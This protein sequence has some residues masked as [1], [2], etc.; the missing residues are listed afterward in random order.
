MRAVI[1]EAFGPIENAAIGEAPDPTPGPGEVLVDV[2]ATAA[3]Y[4]D[5]LLIAGKHQSRPPLPYIPGKGPA[6]VVLGLGEGVTGFAPGD[7]VLAMCEP[8][9]GFA[10]RVAVPASSCHRIPDRLGFAEAA[11]MALIYDTAW[12]ALRERGRYQ[13]GE[14]VLVLG[15]TGGVGLAAIGLAKA[16]GAR[17]LAGV[18]TRSKTD[19]VREA[20]ADAVIDLDRADLKDSLRDQVM[21]AT[22]DHGADI[23]IDP[24]GDDIFDA[25]LRAVAWCGRYIVIG[26]AAGRIPS[27]KANYLLVKNIDVGGLQIADYRKRR[28]DKTAQCFAELF[29]LYEADRIAPPPTTVLPFERFGEALGA[30]ADRSAR[31][32]IVMVQDDDTG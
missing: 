29:A 32:R 1:V 9:G 10:G 5:L 18:S 15:A 26:F 21:A 7:R 31:G 4:V 30:I 12:F 8:G 11:A 13:D 27:V 14:T 22:G 24:L 17:V 16:L 19:L 28:P 3:N 6:G 23:V 25:A 2:R 20:G